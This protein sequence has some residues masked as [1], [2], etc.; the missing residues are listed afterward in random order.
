MAHDRYHAATHFQYGS[1]ELAITDLLSY[2]ELW[3]ATHTFL[4]GKL[5]TSSGSHSS[6]GNW[7]RVTFD[8]VAFESQSGLMTNAGDYFT[9]PPSLGDVWR[10]FAR[11]TFAAD[12]GNT[13]R[14]LRLVR[15]ETYTTGTTPDG[16]G[17]NLAIAYAHSV[18]GASSQRQSCTIEWIGELNGED[19]VTVEAYQDS[20]GT[21]AYETAGALMAFMAEHLGPLR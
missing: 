10:L 13:A 1:D 14:N 16:A 3:I 6:S 8:A 2:A 4:G 11:V 18:G 15:N 21:V 5:H 17:T 12:A 19:I 20:G 9:V 7:R